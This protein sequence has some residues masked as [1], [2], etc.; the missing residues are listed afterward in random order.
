MKLYFNSSSI[1][2]HYSVIRSAI[3]TASCLCK[4]FGTRMAHTNLLPGDTKL[5]TKW[6]SEGI[7]QDKNNSE[8]K[9]AV[10]QILMYCVHANV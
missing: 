1:I 10:Q 4:S 5:S 9:A 2:I 3:Q 8:V 7:V 6:K